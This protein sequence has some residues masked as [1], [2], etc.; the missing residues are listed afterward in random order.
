MSPPHYTISPEG[1][2]DHTCVFYFLNVNTGK[3]TE[4]GSITRACKRCSK[5]ISL[6]S[7]YVPAQIKQNHIRVCERCLEKQLTAHVHCPR[8]T[9]TGILS[10]DQFKQCQNPFLY[11]N[12]RTWFMKLYSYV[13]NWKWQ[14]LYTVQLN[15][16]TKLKKTE[17]YLLSICLVV[18]LLVSVVVN[19]PPKYFFY[20]QMLLSLFCHNAIVLVSV[21]P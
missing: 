2:I 15:F 9:I 3:E 21:T 8:T 19:N 20:P 6:K 4:I 17:W 10:I 13:L 1:I 5:V 11:W 7:V 18:S 12:R 16:G 14:V